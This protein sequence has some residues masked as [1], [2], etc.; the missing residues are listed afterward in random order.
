[1]EQ[2]LKIR[3]V[4][5]DPQQFTIRV[6]NKGEFPVS[7]DGKVVVA[8]SEKIRA[9]EMKYGDVV[10]ADRVTSDVNYICIMKAG[11]VVRKVSMGELF[12]LRKDAGGYGILSIE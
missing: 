5:A 9:F 11:R 10:L 8:Y 6:P 7:E 1:M 3:I 4:A 12:I 2:T